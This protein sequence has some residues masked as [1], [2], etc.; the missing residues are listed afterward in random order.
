[1][2]RLLSLLRRG[3]IYWLPLALLL[4]AALARLAIP[5]VLDRLSLFAFDIQ[6]VP[7]GFFGG[8]TSLSLFVMVVIGGL[9]S[10]PGALFG[11]AYVRIAQIYATGAAQLLVTGIGLLAILLLLPSGL[12]SL[13]YSARD[14]VLRRIARRRRIAVPSLLEDVGVEEPVALRGEAAVPFAV[15]VGAGG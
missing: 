5:E 1:M 3:V 7:A 9:G 10:V 8:D 15:G 14:E 2:K 12:G 4:L 6:S 11:A 13:L